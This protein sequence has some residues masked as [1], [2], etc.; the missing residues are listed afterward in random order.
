MEHYLNQYGVDI[1]F[2]M[3]RSLIQDE[4]S[5]L[6]IMSATTQ[7]NK[8]LAAVQPYCS[9]IQCSRTGP[10][11]SAAVPG[12]THTEATAGIIDYILL[13]PYSLK[14]SVVTVGVQQYNW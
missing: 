9:T 2:L 8:Q 3:R 10:P 4:P 6:P 14:G 7:T 13:F 1:C 5:G 11:L 12:L